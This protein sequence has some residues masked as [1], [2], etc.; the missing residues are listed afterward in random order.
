MK[1]NRD[2]KILWE[3]YR[4]LFKQ[5][6]P[7]GDFDLL[8]ENAEI[9][10]QGRKHIPYNDYVIDLEEMDKIIETILRKYRIPVWRRPSYRFAIYLGCSP[11]T[12]TNDNSS[13]I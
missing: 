9:D 4:E 6:D 10:E 1:Q 13:K 8:V 7:S 12:K 11:K 5:S 3:I 2:E